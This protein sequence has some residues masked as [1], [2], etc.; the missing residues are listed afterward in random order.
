LQGE[1]PDHIEPITRPG[2]TDLCSRHRR[3]GGSD[4]GYVLVF[5][6][7]EHDTGVVGDDSACE[8]R[9]LAFGERRVDRDP[10]LATEALNR[11]IGAVSL[12]LVRIPVV[13]REMCRWC[14]Q[15]MSSNPLQ[16][17]ALRATRQLSAVALVRNYPVALGIKEK[18]IV[19]IM[20]LIGTCRE[21]CIR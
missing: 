8:R 11:L 14:V 2:G 3:Q 13:G 6:A 1:G 7:D 15:A 19:D 5:P 16:L 9:L 10:E 20:W 18:G 12:R 4:G 17:C 21:H